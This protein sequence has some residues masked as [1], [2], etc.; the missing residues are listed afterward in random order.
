MTTE[1]KKLFGGIILLAAFAVVLAALFMPI[2]DGRNAMEELDSLYNSISKGSAYHIEEIKEEV[3]AH[4][5]RPLELIL[6]IEGVERQAGVAAVLGNSGANVQATEAGLAVDGDLKVLLTACLDDADNMFL[7]ESARLEA[8]YGL[9]GKEA[10]FHWWIAL[11]AMDRALKREGRFDDSKVVN[12]VIT[13]G[14]EF[15][16]NYFGIEPM[17]I[18]DKMGI[19]IISL[20]FY[21]LYTI[22]YGYAI[23]LI[24]EGCGLRLSH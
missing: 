23:I 8:A 7:N 5:A 20:A 16:Y 15:A 6:E 4:G 10:L 2:M 13:K 19:V 17:R 1:R 21:V 3:T 22:W 14:V 12:T 24:F 9:G 18:S 11:K